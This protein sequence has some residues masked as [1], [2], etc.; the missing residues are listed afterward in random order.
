MSF[1]FYVVVI[2]FSSALKKIKAVLIVV[3]ELIDGFLVNFC[4]YSEIIN[5]KLLS[6]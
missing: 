2:S 4:K 1:P 6:V 3:F 5:V